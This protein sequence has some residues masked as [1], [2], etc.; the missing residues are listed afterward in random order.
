MNCSQLKKP[1]VCILPDISGVVL[2]NEIITGEKVFFV[3]VFPLE[4]VFKTQYSV[5]F[6]MGNEKQTYSVHKVYEL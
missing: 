4:S 6:K 1:I 2:W 3:S 5:S